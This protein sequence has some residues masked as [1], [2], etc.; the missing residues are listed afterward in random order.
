ML[1]SDPGVMSVHRP[2]QDVSPGGAPVTHHCCP[3]REGHSALFCPSPLM[4][5]GSSGNP[6]VSCALAVTLFYREAEAMNSEDRLLESHGRSTGVGLCGYSTRMAWKCIPRGQ[7]KALFL[8][9][10]DS[11]RWLGE[12]EL[13]LV[14]TWLQSLMLQGDFLPFYRQD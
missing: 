9:S 7:D 6:S 2:Q 10:C 4:S 12:S 13:Y 8:H 11:D 1:V 3:G 14:G 5:C